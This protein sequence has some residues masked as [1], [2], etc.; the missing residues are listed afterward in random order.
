MTAVIGGALVPGKYLRTMPASIKELNTLAEQIPGTKILGGPVARFGPKGDRPQQ[1][2]TKKYDY[3]SVGDTDAF[4]FDLLGGRKPAQRKRTAEE[5]NEWPVLGAAAI[6]QHPDFPTPLIAEIETYRGCIRYAHGGCSFCIEPQ[7]GKPQFRSIASIVS[8]VK[9]LS[10]SGLHNFRLGAQTCFFSYD[11]DADNGDYLPNPAAI[12]KL[13]GQIRKNAEVNILHIDNVNP[14]VIAENPEAATQI[15]K[16]IVKHCTPGNVAALGME[17]ADP[18][19]IKANNLNSTPEQVFRAIE[20][21]NRH[22]AARGEN[23]MP[24]ILPGINF[25]GGLK[26]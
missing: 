5:W 7:Y 12:E 16:S 18:A 19:V 15:V 13:L 10:D 2:S 4:I 14:A 26:G 8:E 9:A 24:H 22:G 20:I 3:L 17:S 6:M 1:V 11:P 23:G 21:I 25:L